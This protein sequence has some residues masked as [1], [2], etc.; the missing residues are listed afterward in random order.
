VAD[1]LIRNVAPEL[2]RKIKERA[3]KSHHSLSEEAKTLIQRGLSVPP[4]TE[5][6][7]TFLFSLVEDRYRGDDL[8]FER[9]DMVSP[10]P[11]FD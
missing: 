1:L 7:G 6:L 11:E 3:R 8:M 4:P 9:N 5:K 10:P 2:R